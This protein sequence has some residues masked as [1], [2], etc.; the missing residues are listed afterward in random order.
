LEVIDN[1]NENVLRVRGA[2]GMLPDFDHVLRA[3]RWG[4][5]FFKKD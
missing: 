2:Y 3:N 4:R 5:G 1:E